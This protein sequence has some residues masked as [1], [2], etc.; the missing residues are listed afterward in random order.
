VRWPETETDGSRGKSRLAVRTLA[1]PLTDVGYY[2]PLQVTATGL[3][4]ERLLSALS[5]HV[6]EACPQAEK[7]LAQCW[8]AISAISTPLAR[9]SHSIHRTLVV[10]C[11]QR[12]STAQRQC[13][14]RL[15]QCGAPPRIV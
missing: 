1:K 11:Y 10:C 13:M 14:R 5:A 8:H 6:Q 4:S 9:S 7:I 3:M 15:T 2:S 12:M